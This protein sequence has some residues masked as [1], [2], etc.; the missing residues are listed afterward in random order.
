MSYDIT[1]RNA[2]PDDMPFFWSSILNHLRHSAYASKFIPTN[3]YYW[4][5]QRLINQALKR[6]N[7]F[8]R[9]AALAEDPDTVIG[10]VWGNSKP[11]TLYY[12]YCKKAFR[13]MGISKLL[14]E[15][16]FHTHK[17]IFC[18]FLSYDGARLIQKY[19]QLIHNPYL[20]DESIWQTYQQ[21][22]NAGE[23]DLQNLFQ[24]NQKQQR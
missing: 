11:Q 4:H 20:M 2:R 21:A 7:N 14:V 12:S 15:K 10:I 8:V 16:S 22:L 23:V 9:V 18:P 3:L 17:Q 5:M 13:L 19:S 1:I 6:E 24:Y